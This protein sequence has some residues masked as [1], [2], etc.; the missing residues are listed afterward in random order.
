MNNEFYLVDL[1]GYGYSEMSKQEKVDSGKF[2]EDYLVNGN[3]IKLIVLLLDIRHKPTEDDKLMYE[4]I[5]KEN[6]P[7]I[8]VTNKADKI[9]VTK[10][11]TEVDKIKEILGISYSTIIPFS[12]ERKIYTEKAWSEIEKFLI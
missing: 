9:A 11:D 6:L 8:V 1:P 3:N 12:S 7:F 5:L 2:I 10:V 4:F